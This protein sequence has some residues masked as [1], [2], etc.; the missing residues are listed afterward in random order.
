M[1]VLIQQAIIADPSSPHFNQ[2]LDI[3]IADGKIDSIAKNI[4]RP[5]D[6]IVRADGLHVSGIAAI[7]V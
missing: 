6:Y 2:Q 5:A 7:L 1:T 3:F 4:D